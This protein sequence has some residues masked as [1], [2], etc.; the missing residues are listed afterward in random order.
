MVNGSNMHSE[1]K[2]RVEVLERVYI[3]ISLYSEFQT[4]EITVA[5]MC[6]TFTATLTKGTADHR[7]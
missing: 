7:S 1:V 6:T 5:N 4:A 3:L 2:G